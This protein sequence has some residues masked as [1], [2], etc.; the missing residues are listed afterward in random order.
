MNTCKKSIKKNENI[1]F[2][3]KHGNI[4]PFNSDEILKAA[5]LSAERV[6]YKLS[7]AEKDMLIDHVLSMIALRDS[8]VIESSEMHIIVENALRKVQPIVADS[9]CRFRDN[10]KEWQEMLTECIAEAN[11]IQFGSGTEAEKNDNANADRTLVSTK[12]CS[13]FNVFNKKLFI[14]FFLTEKEKQACRD[15]YIYVHDMSARRDTMNCCLFDLA[16]VLDGGFY[17]SSNGGLFY[18]EPKSL[19]V[20]FDVT[21]DVILSAASQQYGGFTI[22]EFDKISEKYA[23]RTYQKSLKRYISRGIELSV[24]EEMAYEDVTNEYYAGWQGLEYKLNSVASSRGDYPFVT[25]TFGIGT[26]KWARLCSKICCDVRKNGQG[27]HG[28]KKPVLFAKLVFLYDENLHGPG[29]ELEDIFDAAVDCSSK[30]MYPDY[31]SLSGDG[32]YG[33]VPFMY[34]NYGV[35]VSPMGCR[36]FLSPFFEKGGFYP[37]DEM[38]KPVVVGRFNVGAV[39]L[40][41]PMIYMKAKL[42]GKDFWSVLDFYLNMIRSIHCRTYA[43]LAT[44]KASC[45]PLAFMEGGFYKGHLRAGDS[46]APCLESATASF[47][48]TALNELQFLHTGKGID[49]DNGFSVQVID[50][51]SAKLSEFKQEDHHLYAIY[52]TPAESLCGK[53]V[54]QF[55]DKYGIIKGVSDRP[56]ISNSFHCHVSCDITPIEAQ[57]KEYELFHKFL[58]GHIQY[59]R[60]PIDYNLAAM[61]RLIRRAMK[62]GFYEGVNMSMATCEECGHKQLEMKICPRCGSKNISQIDRMN[63]YLQWTKT[64]SIETKNA[65]MDLSGNIDEIMKT[66]DKEA[67]GATR[68]SDFK[69]AEIADRVSK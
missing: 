44:L 19:D 18:N 60:Y 43:Y 66:V 15:G 49:A 37:A 62:M 6:M 67:V 28:A 36:A 21:G 61:K 40:H 59:V 14:M 56:Y 24:A 23:E 34:K 35:V 9:Y 25:V 64:A 55:R 20:F 52:G 57:D 46:I 10:K 68:T 16:A 41:L 32:D 53:Q 50:H 4:E 3:D 47:G 42:E 33:S 27:R 29:K 26:G 30:A 65:R 45:N 63:G 1:L 11:S 2:K 5:G 13:I 39:S 69:A 48:I 17:S 54:K 38:D 51:I 8:N 58:G 7:K 31:L 12:R 22:A